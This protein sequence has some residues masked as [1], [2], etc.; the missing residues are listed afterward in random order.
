MFG[1]KIFAQI[2]YGTLKMFLLSPQN[3]LYI[4]FSS[5]IEEHVK[6]NSNL[7]FMSSGGIQTSKIWMFLLENLYCGANSE[8]VFRQG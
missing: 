3:N 6:G 1:F 8:I 2:T 5:Y 4:I 7:N